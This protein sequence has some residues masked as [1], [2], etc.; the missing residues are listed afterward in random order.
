MQ[1]AFVKGKHGTRVEGEEGG[2]ELAEVDVGLRQLGPSDKLG[3]SGVDGLL[4]DLACP[5][6][7]PLCQEKVDLGVEE[8]IG[9]G[10]G[11]ERLVY[12]F[13]R[14]DLLIYRQLV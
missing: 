5:V 11:L 4:R 6:W 1:V 7:F 3:R 10:I 8:G 14:F 9:K 2:V 12:N 13:D